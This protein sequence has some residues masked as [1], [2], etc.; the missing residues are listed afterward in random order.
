[1]AENFASK[2]Q[3]LPLLQQSLLRIVAGKAEVLGF[4][5]Y[6]VGGI[7]RDLVLGHPGT[8][9]DIVIVGDAPTLARELA[10]EHGGEVTVHSKFR[11]AIWQVARRDPELAAL[12]DL[13]L[14]SID[15]I[16]ARREI[17]TSPAV[18][19]TVTPGSLQDD[20]ARRD[21]TINTLAIA[22]TSGH[23]GELH[24][25]FSGL[26]DIQNGVVRAL[27]PQSYIDDP[28]RIFRAIRYEQRYAFQ[29]SATDL[30]LIRQARPYLRQL[31]PE[32]LRHELDLILD[33]P[34]A[35]AMLER[36]HELGVFEFIAEELPWDSG[37]RQMLDSALSQLSSPGVGFIPAV[38]GLPHQ[39]ALL[40]AVWLAPLPPARIEKLQTRLLFPLEMLKIIQA[41]SALLADFPSL[42]GS[43][44]SAWVERLDGIPPLALLAVSVHVG[45][46]SRPLTDY[47]RQWRHMHIST[48]GETLKALGLRPGP[49]FQKILWHLR[50]SLLDGE[51]HTLDEEKALLQAIIPR[52]T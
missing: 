24:D 15:L 26:Q 49:A 43:R 40:Y 18:L 20:L 3:T 5:A 13:P 31:S 35:P 25:P 28:T 50:A 2:L 37:L 8:D 30:E 45:P 9:L 33:E 47:S 19:P 51:I 12:A 38:A 32:R 42:A 16:T 44:P 36:L 14:A 48:N 7:P 21:F 46:A 23:Y 10:S 17:Y 27:H 34:R 6:L 29:L 39:R 11:T 4:P 22:L 41:A 1:M 52:Y